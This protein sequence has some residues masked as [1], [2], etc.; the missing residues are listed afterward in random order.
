MQ[1]AM[2]FCGALCIS[3]AVG[4]VVCNTDVCV[5]VLC[6]LFHWSYLPL[7]IQS[8]PEKIAQSL[9]HCVFATVC[10]RIMPLSPKCSEINW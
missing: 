4:C 1:T 8:G 5:T 6:Y 9:V 3:V 7:I 10:N 2:V